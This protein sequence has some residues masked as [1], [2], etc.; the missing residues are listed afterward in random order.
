MFERED[1]SKMNKSVSDPWKNT[2]RN[3]EELHIY[4]E[5]RVL[6]NS[7]YS[8]SRKPPFSSDRCLSDQIRRA[9]ISIMS[10][11]AEGYERGATKEFIQFL[12]IA[13]GSCGEVRAQLCVAHDQGYLNSDEYE[14]MELLARKIA[15]MISNFIAHLQKTR[16]RGEKYARPSRIES[17]KMS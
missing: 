2:A 7:V 1:E 12:Y 15:G 4:Q 14:R 5:S 9:C 11:I 3:F 13:K 16:Y 6:T 10:D 17:E 8:V